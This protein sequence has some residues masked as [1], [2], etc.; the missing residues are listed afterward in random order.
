MLLNFF[1]SPEYYRGK[2]EGL[3]MEFTFKEHDN[4]IT[5]PEDFT[6]DSCEIDNCYRQ[7]KEEFEKTHFKVTSHVIYQYKLIP[8]EGRPGILGSR[9]NKF[10][11][12]QY[13]FP[14]VG[15]VLNYF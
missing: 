8:K 13:K 9:I 14:L 7:V 15:F 10:L 1:K 5:I 4:S 11:L 12:N 3:G 2:F 6:D